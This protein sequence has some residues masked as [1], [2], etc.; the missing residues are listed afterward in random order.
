MYLV[1]DYLFYDRKWTP[2]RKV[3]VVAKRHVNVCVPSPMITMVLH[4]PVHRG[5]SS[6][7]KN[8]AVLF[9]NRNGTM[10]HLAPSF[11]SFPIS[12]TNQC[13][14]GQDQSM[15]RCIHCLTPCDALYRKYGP[16]TIKLIQC[17]HCRRDVDPYCEREW[18]LVLIDCI[19]LREEAYRHVL[20]HRM[21]DVVEQRNQNTFLFHDHLWILL[22]ASAFL[23][24]QP[25]RG[26]T[27][28]NPVSSLEIISTNPNL[29]T[30]KV[31]PLIVVVALSVLQELCAVIIFYGALVVWRTKLIPQRTIDQSR[32]TYTSSSQSTDCT[33]DN[34]CPT[35]S[36]SSLPRQFIV[37][38]CLPAVLVSLVT[39]GLL[40]GKTVI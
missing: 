29:S 22:A 16:S 7:A 28:S 18:L 15:Y 33:K 19:L 5:T 38:F 23:R 24:V 11:P 14:T 21:V 8:V 37:A 9:I 25:M 36:P 6:L 30:G 39:W 31:L 32:A 12:N 27:P 3:P 40:Y 13:E 20:C 1:S 17:T 26:V 34:S 4:N 10:N 2:T 35:L